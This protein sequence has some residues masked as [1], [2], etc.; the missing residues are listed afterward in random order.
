MIGKCIDTLLEETLMIVSF[1]QGI[2][3]GP[4]GCILHLLKIEYHSRITQGLDG[5]Q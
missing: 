3:Q 2:G 5:F 4:C 1:C